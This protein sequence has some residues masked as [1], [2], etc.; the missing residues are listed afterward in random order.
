MSKNIINVLIVDDTRIIRERIKRHLEAIN[1]CNLQ[2]HVFEADTYESAM[3]LMNNTLIDV[4]L[5]DLQIDY[6]QAIN[7]VEII[8]DSST[9][10][11]A[12]MSNSLNLQHIVD[13]IHTDIDV[14]IIKAVS[15]KKF[16]EGLDGI[17]SVLICG[18]RIN[19]QAPD[20]IRYIKEGIISVFD[21]R[22]L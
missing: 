22:N 21:K 15:V 9:A 11:V 7:T 13:S 2:F 16:R 14:Y 3:D 5:I 10:N 4:V 12:A 1:K 20:V 17:L 6:T 8:K 18:H 19:G